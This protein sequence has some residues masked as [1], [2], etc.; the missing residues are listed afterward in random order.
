MD[1]S[2]VTTETSL[3]LNQDVHLGIP[4]LVHFEVAWPS[5]P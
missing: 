2:K 5:W 4:A 1:G 3:D